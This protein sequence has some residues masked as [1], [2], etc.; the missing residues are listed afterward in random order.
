MSADGPPRGPAHDAAAISTPALLLLA[1]AAFVTELALFGGVGVVVHD[2]VGGGV[3]GWVAGAV[4]VGLVLL[5]WGRFMAPKGARRL[6]A[7]PRSAV[8]AVLVVAVAASLAVSGHA[9]WAW[10]VGLLGVVVVA[11]QSVLHRPV[12]PTPQD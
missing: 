12:D 2:L 6:A 1:V 10:V 7:G 9:A 8:A 4:A 3:A 11:A 5:L